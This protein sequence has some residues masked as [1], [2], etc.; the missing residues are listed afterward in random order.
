MRFG[1]LVWVISTQACV[2]RLSLGFG[3]FCSDG[4]GPT[5]ATSGKE[6]GEEAFD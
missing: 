6:G 4:H 5:P 3:F 2:L 1:G